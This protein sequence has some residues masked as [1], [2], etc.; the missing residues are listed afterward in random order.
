MEEAME[1]VILGRPY[2]QVVLPLVKTRTR[3]RNR[4]YERYVI[5]VPRWLGEKLNPRGERKVFVLAYIT[6]PWIHQLLPLDPD[7]PIYTRL[8]EEAKTELYYQG[9]DPTAKP[10][11]RVVYIAAEEEEVKQLGLDPE[12]PITLRDIVE[13]VLEKTVKERALVGQVSQA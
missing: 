3:S 13:A 7:D 12:K 11:S 6:K 1:V 4:V 9:R 5:N 10:K 8:P 2:L